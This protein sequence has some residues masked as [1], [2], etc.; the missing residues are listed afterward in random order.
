MRRS[1]S[2]LAVLHCPLVDMR[3]IH[4]DRSRMKYDDGS[5]NLACGGD[6]AAAV[7]HPSMQSAVLVGCAKDIALLIFVM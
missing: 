3:S 6:S 7:P 1:A 5:V 4:V 2:E